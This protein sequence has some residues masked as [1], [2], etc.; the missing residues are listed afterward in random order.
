MRVILLVLLLSGCAAPEV[1][2][3]NISC[4]VSDAYNGVKCAHQPSVPDGPEVVGAT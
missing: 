4:D 3:P 2:E 1:Y